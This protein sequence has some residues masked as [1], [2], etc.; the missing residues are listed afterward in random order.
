MNRF[1]T[2]ML[3][4]MIGCAAAL[5]KPMQPRQVLQEPVSEERTRVVGL[6]LGLD[7]DSVAYDQSIKAARKC[8][9]CMG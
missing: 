6:D 1:V 8:G 3:L 2:I 7:N 4:A 9:F 5:I